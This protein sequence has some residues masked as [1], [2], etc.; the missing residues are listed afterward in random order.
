MALNALLV[1]RS[2][3]PVVRLSIAF[4]KCRSRLTKLM[5]L[6]LMKNLCERSHQLHHSSFIDVS[7]H[8]RIFGAF[9]PMNFSQAILEWISICFFLVFFFNFLFSSSKRQ[10][11]LPF[12]HQTNDRKNFFFFHQ[13]KNRK[14][15]YFWF[16]GPVVRCFIR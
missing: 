16:T 14:T 2:A 11:K 7:Q 9:P 5:K 4:F 15:Q 8:G 1:F 3:A 6:K 10:K 12:F 13:S